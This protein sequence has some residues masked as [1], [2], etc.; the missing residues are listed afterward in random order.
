MAEKI[1]HRP[2]VRGG[3]REDVGAVR[4]GQNVSISPADY[5]FKCGSGDQLPLPGLRQ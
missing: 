2:I 3:I 1:D 4:G 5:V